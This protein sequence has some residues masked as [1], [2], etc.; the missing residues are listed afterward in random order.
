MTPLQCI[1][2]ETVNSDL[3]RISRMGI[4]SKFYTDRLARGKHHTHN[5]KQELRGRKI[6]LVDVSTWFH[7]FLVSPQVVREHHTSPPIP[8]N[9]FLL[10]FKEKHASLVALG[11]DPFYIF[12][13]TRSPLKRTEDAA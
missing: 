3:L 5:I 8:V 13:G 12:D 6:V 4:K 7:I 2:V 11:V 10:K 9:S 1:I